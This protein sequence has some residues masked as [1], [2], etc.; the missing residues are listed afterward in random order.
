MGFIMAEAL[1]RFLEPKQVIHGRTDYLRHDV[2]GW[3]PPPGKATV[4]THEYVAHYDVNSLGMNDEPVEG[5]DRRSRM[6]I[7]ALRDSHTFAVGVSQGK[8][9]PNV[10]ESFL[11]KK[12]VEAGTVYNAGSVGY[13]L[14]Q[15]L[16]RM[17]DLEAVLDPQIVVIGFS[18]ATDLY[19]FIP[20]RLG[21]FVYGHPWGRVY[22]DLD[23]DGSLLEVHDLVAK[24]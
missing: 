8:V 15:Y 11:F 1:A 17:R 22:F 18:L 19:D 2:L 3:V 7:L 6:R 10:L 13:S 12:D 16:L 23:Q 4:S 20:P 14:G 9:S 24:T 5:T 21:G